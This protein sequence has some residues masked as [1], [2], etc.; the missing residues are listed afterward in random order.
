MPISDPSLSLSFIY[1]DTYTFQR[2]LSVFHFLY[3]QFS[4]S[5]PP[6]SKP[7]PTVSCWVRGLQEAAKA[8]SLLSIA[9]STMQ[10]LTCVYEVVW[11]MKCVILIWKVMSWKACFL[12]HI[13]YWNLGY[14]PD[15]SPGYGDVEFGCP[16]S[17][18]YYPQEGTYT[19]FTCTHS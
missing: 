18:Y 2:T 8:Q 6:H 12:S 9:S 3:I 11:M 10:V 15:P 17:Q 5:G 16:Q 1:T 4:P 19:L 7:F 14:P 13:F